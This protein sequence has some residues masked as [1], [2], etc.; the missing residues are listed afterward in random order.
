MQLC[1]IGRADFVVIILAFTC[2]M[3]LLY[4]VSQ[5]TLAKLLQ[6]RKKKKEHGARYDYNTVG[7]IIVSYIVLFL[8][9]N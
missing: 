8:P 5:L 4:L 2:S 1:R 3:A 6:E 7:L 9:F